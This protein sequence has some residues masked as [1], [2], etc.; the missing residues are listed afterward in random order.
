[1]VRAA[2]S[3]GSLP[4]PPNVKLALSWHGVRQDVR[5]R[6]LPLAAKCSLDELQRT[7]AAVNRR[8]TASVMIEYLMLAGVNDAQADARELVAWLAG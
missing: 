8:Q 7:V 1:M 6:L 2:Q 5:Q 4:E 3:A